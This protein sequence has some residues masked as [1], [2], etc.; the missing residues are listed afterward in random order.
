MKRH[1]LSLV[2][3]IVSVTAF[4]TVYDNTELTKDEN[5]IT[6]SCLTDGNNNYQMIIVG[7]NLQGLGGTFCNKDGVGGYDIRTNMT[8]STDKKTIIINIKSDPAPN[9]YTPLYV[10][11]PGEV[12]FG[13][14]AIDWKT[15]ESLD[16]V[17]EGGEEEGGEE[18]EEPKGVESATEG[19]IAHFATPDNVRATYKVTSDNDGNITFTVSGSEINFVEIQIMNKI[20]TGMTISEDKTTATYTLMSQ[21]ANTDLYF[22]FLI[23]VGSMV[24]NEMTAQNLTSTDARIFRY[25]YIKDESEQTPTAIES[26]IEAETLAT[27]YNIAGKAVRTNVNAK[28]AIKGLASGV[29]IIKSGKTSRKVI[30]K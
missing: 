3:M 30:V 8:V 25:T 6:L 13:E 15:V 22:R 26:Q 27:V 17:G 2:A 5:K 9:V 21:E 29:Y 10:M 14:L 24:G 28:D 7:E 18:T 16:N 1:L 19:N 11:M 20:N 4:A 12:N 23:N